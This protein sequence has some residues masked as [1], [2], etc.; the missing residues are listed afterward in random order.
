MFSTLF[1][2]C[3]VWCV[4]SVQSVERDWHAA[5]V[6]A[7]DVE[8]TVTSCLS[9]VVGPHH[10]ISNPNPYHWCTLFGSACLIGLSTCE[11]GWEEVIWH[12]GKPV[13]KVVSSYLM[14]QK[15]W[16]S[17]G[18]SHSQREHCRSIPVDDCRRE[19]RASSL[20]AT[21]GP[22]PTNSSIPNYSEQSTI[23]NIFITWD[24]AAIIT[25]INPPRQDLGWSRVGLGQG[26]TMLNRIH[27]SSC[28][29]LLV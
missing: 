28:S 25:W 16:I 15:P 27:H 10:D 11:A 13:P 2:Y 20:C 12:Q 9:S 24:P 7:S 18:Y 22:H 4:N 8:T 14:L 29:L 6:H 26:P 17:H 21:S 5:L 1:Q 19:S 23:P 3:I